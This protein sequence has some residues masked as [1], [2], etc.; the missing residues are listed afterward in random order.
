MH[1]R[2]ILNIFIERIDRTGGFDNPLE[3]TKIIIS[4]DKNF[5]KD[6]VVL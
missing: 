4:F 3:N 2:Q 6:F 1:V 5:T